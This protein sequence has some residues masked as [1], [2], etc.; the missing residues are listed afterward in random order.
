MPNSFIFFGPHLG[1]EMN[2]NV[3]QNK[4]NLVSVCVENRSDPGSDGG[5][6]DAGHGVLPARPGLD[7]RPAA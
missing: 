1:C 2:F 7:G 5:P 6:K 4:T 3:S